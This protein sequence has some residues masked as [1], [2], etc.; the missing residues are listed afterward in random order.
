MRQL[1]LLLQQ[2]LAGY[3]V[4]LGDGALSEAGAKGAAG[5]TRFPRAAREGV[6]LRQ[7][8]LAED[9]VANGPPTVAEGTSCKVVFDGLLYNHRE[10]SDRFGASSS[11]A[12]D[13]AD[14]IL[15]AYLHWGADVLHNIKGIFALFIW[16]ERQHVLLCARDPLGVYPLFYSDTGRE[17]LFSTSIEALIQHR[18]VSDAV[19]R[20]ALADYLSYR[21]E[22]L[23]ETFYEAVNRVPPG[24][25]MRVEGTR[26][27]EYRY[28]DP[29][30][31]ETEVDWVREDELERF[32]ELLDQAVDRCLQLGQAGIFLSGGLDSVSVAA[33]A[34]DNSRR[35][36]LSNPWALSLAFPDPEAN[37]ETVQRNVAS[38]LGLPQELVPFYEAAG[39]Q[40]LLASAMAMSSRQTLPLYSPWAPAY[41]YLGLEGKRRGCRVILT[42]QGGDEWLTVSPFYA[43]DLFRSL[44][45][46]GLY[47][48]W[49]AAH[50]SYEFSRLAFMRN[51]MWRF[52]VR[53]WMGVAARKVLRRTAPGVLRWRWRWD[54]SRST[55]DWVAPDPALRAEIA[56]RAVQSRSSKPDPRS[57]YFYEVRQTLEHPLISME[58]EE[59]FE[60]GRRLGFPVL[61]PYWD[62]DLVTFLY[63][64]PPELLNQ[65]ERTKALVRQTVARR[66]PHLNF[67]RQ[68]KVQAMNFFSSILSE[69]GAR[70]WQT[71]GGAPALAELGIVDAPALNSGV[72]KLLSGTQSPRETHRIRDILLVESWLR[73]R[74]GIP[75][76]PTVEEAAPS[77]P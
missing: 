31:D 67:E 64:T 1:Q 23:E 58:M 43:A 59:N 45:F 30:P 5:R 24:H 40:G 51:I 27:Q 22:K 68:K 55:P 49:F 66:F 11:P 38:G 39:P 77:V 69:E 2:S 37:E 53:P 41:Q 56:Q 25:A 62:A 28:W 29:V 54:F 47:R 72:S 63:R 33:V 71:M 14:L 9:E 20:L 46:K 18:K 70:L 36:G 26:R 73:G 60:F 75:L 19:N 65:G 44:D 4:S 13:D 10:L 35:K 76:P 6:G 50:R 42:G 61:M 8:V 17:L 16:D 12:T 57:F 52:G 32:D 34:A 21:T 3:V 48:L 15:R 74:L 7:G